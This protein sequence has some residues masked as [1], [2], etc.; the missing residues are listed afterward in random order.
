MKTLCALL[1]LVAACNKDNPYYCEENPDHNCT[2]DGGTANGDTP[3]ACTSAD[4][5]SGTLPACNGVGVCVA[6][7][8]TDIGACSGTKPQCSTMNT[9]RGCTMNSECT[10]GACMPD[11]SCADAATALYATPSGGATTCT[12]ADKCSIEQAFVLASST[13]KL[14][15]L[16]PGMYSTAGTISTAKEV[17][18]LGRDATIYKAGAGNEVLSLTGGAKL[19]IFYATIKNGD[20]GTVGHGIGCTSSKLTAR[21]VTIQEND[22]NG[23][24]AVGCDVTIDRSTFWA[25]GAGAISLAGAAQPF[26]VTNNVIY[27]NG[28][29]V[30][31]LFGGVKLTYTGSPSTAQLEFNTIIDNMAK[32]GSGNSGG[33]VCGSSTFPIANNIVARNVLG[34]STTATDAQKYGDCVPMTSLIQADV[35]DLAF[36]NATTYPYVLKIGA[37]STAKDAA[38]TASTVTVDFEGDDRP[39]NGQKDIGA[40]EYK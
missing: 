26:S 13:Q 2:I 4:D 25:N 16:D 7:T 11:G 22:A 32:T 24:N 12:T 10:S 1:V 36:T 40:D 21:F 28:S 19:T 14:I 37:T 9:C 15:V 8:A 17:T 31:A 6:C 30:S 27:Q 29:T 20:D 33:I 38:T 5:C 34:T 35:V 23:V 18:V 3:M 39:Q